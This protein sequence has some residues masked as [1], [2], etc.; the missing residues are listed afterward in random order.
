MSCTCNEGWVHTSRGDSFVF[1]KHYTDFLEERRCGDD[2]RGHP[3]RDH[4]FS[5][6]FPFVGLSSRVG[7]SHQS[8]A[9]VQVHCD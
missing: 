4:G 2:F 7:L 1:F 6:L 9:I 3:E 5:E 8:T